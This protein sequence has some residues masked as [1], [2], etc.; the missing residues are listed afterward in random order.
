MQI[1][2]LKFSVQKSVLAFLVI[3]LL[4]NFAGLWGPAAASP[5][6]GRAVAAVPRSFV[7]H[8]VV[9]P[10]QMINQ[11]NEDAKRYQAV[12]A[13]SQQEVAADAQRGVAPAG[14]SSALGRVL[15]TMP[16]GAVALV[17]GGAT[18]Y[19]AGGVYY[20]PIFQG[21]KVVYQMVGNPL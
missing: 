14:P 13:K 17:I 11:A 7:P 12:P 19:M 3:L 8:R 18:Y 20:R 4:G 5:G 10:Q 9:M 6:G 15:D 16:D 21:D 2:N 1:A